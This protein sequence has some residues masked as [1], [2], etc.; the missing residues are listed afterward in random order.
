MPECPYPL[1]VNY[2][3]IRNDYRSLYSHQPIRISA[4]MTVR[5]TREITPRT[6]A[7]KMGTIKDVKTHTGKI[8]YD[9]E[10]RR[11]GHPMLYKGFERKCDAREPSLEL[12]SLQTQEST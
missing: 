11:K 3:Q 1:R 4:L 8:V 5:T 2:G 10:V 6:K 9:A 7:A 12:L